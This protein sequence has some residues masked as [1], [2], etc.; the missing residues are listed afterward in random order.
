[1]EDVLVIY[2]KFDGF[3]VD[4]TGHTGSKG[5]NAYNLDLSN[6]RANSV[7]EWF[8]K[9]GV[10]ESAMTK[11]GVGESQP[12]AENE[13]DGVDNPAGRS[14][15]RRVEIAAK[16]REKVTALPD[17]GKRGVDPVEPPKPEKVPKIGAPKVPKAPKV[18]KAQR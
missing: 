13:I 18:D 15:N 8:L 14:L 9:Q 12:V 3:Q 16:T 10:S 1:M 6:R 4:I 2:R 17:A 11:K 5:A 7:F